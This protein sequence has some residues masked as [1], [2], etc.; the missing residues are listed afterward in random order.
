MI[1]GVGIGDMWLQIA[2]ISA[3]EEG[4]EHT[5]LAA[6]AKTGPTLLCV[7]LMFR[8]GLQEGAAAICR[9]DKVVKPLWDLG[10]ARDEETQTL[11]VPIH[12]PTELLAQGFE[13]NDLTPVVA[14]FA[15]AMSKALA[16]KAPLDALLEQVRAAAKRK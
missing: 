1:R 14:P 5:W 8:R 4:N 13:Q 7:Q 11:F 9:D 12:I 15:T 2:E 3:D 10:F 6:V 16:A